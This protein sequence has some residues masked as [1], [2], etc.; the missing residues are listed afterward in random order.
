[1]NL[2]RSHKDNWSWRKESSRLYDVNIPIMELICLMI[3]SLLM[4]DSGGLLIFL[5]ESSSHKKP[6]P[7]PLDLVVMIWI[8][9]K[10]SNYKTPLKCTKS[11]SHKVASW[12]INKAWDMHQFKRWC[13]NQSWCTFIAKKMFGYTMVYFLAMLHG[14]IHISNCLFIVLFMGG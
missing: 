2:Q 11:C 12:K 9:S 4:P 3:S 7:W 14:K 8:S 1:M 10:V 5:L 13:E 6:K